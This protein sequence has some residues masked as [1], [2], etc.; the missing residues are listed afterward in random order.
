MQTSQNPT[1]STQIGYSNQPASDTLSAQPQAQTNYSQNSQKSQPKQIIDFGFLKSFKSVKFWLGLAALILVFVIYKVFTS[2]AS[3][4]V[5]G[6]GKIT[7]K[8]NQVSMLVT[9][10]N[11]GSDAVSA[12]NEGEAGLQVLVDSAKAVGGDEVQINKAFYQVQP[13]ISSSGRGYQVANVFSLE[14]NDVAK[15][16]EM[17]KTLYSNGATTVGNVSFS[18]TKKDQTSLEARKLAVADAKNQAKQLAKSAGK[19]LGR[20]IQISDDNLD[21][22]GAV[23]DTT[24]Q[25]SDFSSVTVTK[26]VTVVY[27][28]W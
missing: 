12:I 11:S 7:F 21:V 14:F 9:R 28:L 8:P 6:Q 3:L 16:S 25:E 26:R 24:N 1:Q 13:S 17:I 10:V 18:S 2:P 22:S 23:S 5:I 4:T 19:R 20:I 15:T 27:S